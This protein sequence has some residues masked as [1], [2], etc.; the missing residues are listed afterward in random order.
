[1]QQKSLR[2]VRLFS[3][4]KWMESFDCTSATIRFANRQ[5]HF[6]I[7]GFIMALPAARA[8]HCKSGCARC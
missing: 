2:Y 8:L 6:H 3:S 7:E 1:M 5:K 4:Y